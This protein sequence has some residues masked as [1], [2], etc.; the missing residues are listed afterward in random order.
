VQASHCQYDAAWDFAQLWVLIGLGLFVVAFGIGVGYLSR[1]GIQLSRIAGAGERSSVDERA[2][3][4]R[5]IPGCR[6]VLVVL[7]VIVWDM[8][9]KPGL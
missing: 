3:L 5:W 4:A 2:L 6:V 1:I 7:I 9:F 8:V